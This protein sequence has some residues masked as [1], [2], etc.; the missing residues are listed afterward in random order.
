M[1]WKSFIAECREVKVWLQGQ[2]IGQADL[3][4]MKILFFAFRGGLAPE[5]VFLEAL[6]EVQE[7][8]ENALKTNCSRDLPDSIYKI[9]ARW[10][11]IF[12]GDSWLLGEI[13]ENLAQQRR[14]VGLF[15]TTPD[16]IEYILRY[17]VKKVDIIAN[18]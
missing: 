14:K 15:Y 4:L 3:L 12:P 7:H 2:G 18:P 11:L 8:K 10:L 1:N 13:Y 5:T 16:V 6:S 9:I 17:T